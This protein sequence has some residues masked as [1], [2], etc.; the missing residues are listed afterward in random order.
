MNWVRKPPEENRMNLVRFEG[1]LSCG[2]QE[3]RCFV[4][5]ALK[6]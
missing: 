6:H 3:V 2:H 4:T 5:A 1:L